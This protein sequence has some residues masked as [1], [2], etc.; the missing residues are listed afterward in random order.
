MLL[1][2][3][4]PVIQPNITIAATII[5]TVDSTLTNLRSICINANIL[6]NH[7]FASM[8]LIRQ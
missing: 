6:H 7:I 5:P 1:S 3:A 4:I 8:W 2:V